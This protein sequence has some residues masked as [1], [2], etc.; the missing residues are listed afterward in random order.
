MQYQRGED[1][2]GWG[3]MPLRSHQE[4][5]DQNLDESSA[6]RYP[7]DQHTAFANVAHSSQHRCNR[8]SMAPGTSFLG[9]TTGLQSQF[10]P[11]VSQPPQSSLSGNGGYDYRAS[12][13]SY[14]QGELV[15][16]QSTIPSSNVGNVVPQSAQSSAGI[17]HMPEFQRR[18][19]HVRSP[20]YD[21]T[22]SELLFPDGAWT[23]VPND[24]QQCG[25]PS[26]H[27]IEVEED[28]INL[29]ETAGSFQEVHLDVDTASGS[30]EPWSHYSVVDQQHPSDMAHDVWQIAPHSTFS[31]YD[32]SPDISSLSVSFELNTG[33]SDTSYPMLGPLADSQL[34]TLAANDTVGPMLASSQ[35]SSMT[36]SNSA[37]DYVDMDYTDDNGDMSFKGITGPARLVTCVESSWKLLTLLSFKAILERAR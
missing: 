36:S 29:D 35:H 9:D 4:A 22:N 25:Q 24:Q 12:P 11:C 34:T 16:P 37:W 26:A 6:D 20:S 30:S 28:T 13:Y 5:G 14:T 17:G 7:E 27:S 3:S 32:A 1:P 18:R 23:H 10:S 31:T 21:S 15:E 2:Y 33:T 8:R 19:P